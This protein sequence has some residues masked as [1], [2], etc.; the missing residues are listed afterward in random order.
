MHSRHPRPLSALAPLAALLAAPAAAQVDVVP[1]CSNGV[2]DRATGAC[3][4]AASVPELGRLY[5]LSA[6]LYVDAAT[7]WVGI[8]STAP[9]ERLH[10]AGGLRVDGPLSAPIGGDLE[11]AAGAARLSLRDQDHLL[12]GVAS[13]V[14]GST[15]NDPQHFVG[16]TIAGGG[17]E[18]AP[19]TAVGPFATI[20]GG[21][22]NQAGDTAVVAGGDLNLAAGLRSTVAGGTNN[23][24]LVRGATVGGGE[25][26]LADGDQATVAGGS[27][28][29][30][31]GLRASVGG[32]SSNQ[33]WGSYA[34][35]PG[36]I[37]NRA[38]GFA[39][40]AAGTGSQ[41]LHQGTFVWSDASGSA[42]TSTA[43][44][45]FLVCAQGGVGINTT[46]PSAALHVEGGS[47]AS[48]AG[49]GYLQLGA[50]ASPNLLLD[51][52]EV[53]ARSAGGPATLYLN[54]EGGD[55]RIGDTQLYVRPGDGV[56]IGSA[57]NPSYDLHLSTLA[58]HGGTAG[59][60]GGGS[61][62]ATSDRRL[63]RDVRALEDALERLLSLR[64]VRFEY[65]DPAAIGE[66]AGVQRGMIAQEVRRVFPEWVHEGPD[67]YL[68]LT[69]S[70]FEALTVEALR[71]LRAE[72]DREIAA[73]Q[74][75]LARLE[76]L[77]GNG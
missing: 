46:A 28:N 41:A 73:L 21:S 33:A 9:E 67:G 35:V 25:G 30:A 53:M 27:G 45:Q 18:S 61:W 42:F 26:N 74:A 4:E 29:D 23:R 31:L 48:L 59:K 15:F 75:R 37:S 64:G 7:G 5:P 34:T 43:D 24:A 38:T 57:G 54:H 60:P 19:N 68:R 77:L 2:R 52:N 16:V 44:D 63:K 55:V 10:V 66:R 62:T 20:G 70:G 58:A 1:Y 40:F 51:E 8:G 69:F 47:D 71:E 50:D 17:W 14:A 12:S 72:K 11:F 32:G 6:D 13:V 3:L 65:V 76:A 49:G 22:G 56:V 36:G 39:S